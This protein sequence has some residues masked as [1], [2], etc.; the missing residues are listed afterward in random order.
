MPQLDIGTYAS[1]LFWL[2]FCFGLLYIFMSHISVP[3][4]GAVLEKRRLY[5]ETTL[6]RGADLESK[7]ESLQIEFEK[8]L[9]DT[10][11]RAHEILVS[12]AHDIGIALVNQ[13]RESSE[14]IMASIQKSQDEIAKRKNESLKEGQQTAEIITREVIQ[15]LINI[16]PDSNKITTMIHQILQSK[17][18]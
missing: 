14:M 16:E 17:G 12:T 7:A 8:V 6:R 3:L 5:I 2:F 11:K 1:Q 9:A 10:R 4:I 13:K 18:T 15:K